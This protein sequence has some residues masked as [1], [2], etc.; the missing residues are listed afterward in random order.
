MRCSR[1]QDAFAT[2]RVSYTESVTEWGGR[3]VNSVV[4]MQGDLVCR[5]LVLPVAGE[6]GTHRIVFERLRG[7]P[8]AYHQLFRKVSKHMQEC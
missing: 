3:E 8:L 1:A 7:D 5:G 4:C 2:L 6:P